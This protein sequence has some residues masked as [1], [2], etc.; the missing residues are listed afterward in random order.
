MLNIVV[1]LVGIY[2]IVLVFLYFYQEKITFFPEKLPKDYIYAFEQDF[3]ELDIK[4][5]DATLLN[6]L[7]FKAKNSKGLIFYLHGNAGSL[8]DWGELAELYTKKHDFFIIDY[9][10]FG[11]S[12]GRIKSQK[13]FYTDVRLAYKT[14]ADKYE[15]KNIIIIGNSIGTASATMLA[16]E[17]EVKLLILQS[18]YY[19]MKKLVTKKYPFVPSFLIK[20]KFKTHEY[21]AKCKMP[22]MIFHGKDDK[23]I[24]CRNAVALQK[25]FKP[26]DQLILL[27]NQGHSAMNNNKIYQDFINLKLETL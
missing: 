7:L 9:R 10:G 2:G 17:N 21:L 11:K 1:L 4:T 15:A 5:A 20:Y 12:E 18:P 16:S 24:P 22:V 13:Q 8:R 27:E 26:S 25:L 3:K 6:A 14:I 23:V 19:S